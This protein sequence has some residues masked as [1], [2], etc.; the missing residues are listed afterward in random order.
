MGVSWTA[1]GEWWF[2]SALGGGLLLLL[3]WLLARWAG[4]APVALA[5]ALRPRPAAGRRARIPGERC[6]PAGMAAP[7]PRRLVAAAPPG[8]GGSAAGGRPPRRA[9]R[10][11]AVPAPAGFAAR[12]GP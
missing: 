2:R 4:T 10:R 7:G 11:A 1:M 8:G 3:G 5:D 6:R 9:G 12:P